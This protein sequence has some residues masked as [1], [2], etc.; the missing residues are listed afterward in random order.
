MFSVDF[1]TKRFT[2]NLKGIQF[3]AIPEAQKKSLFR[4]GFFNKKKM[5][6]YMSK[7]FRNPVKETLRSVLFKVENEDSMIF[8]IKKQKGKGNSPRKYLAP[9]EF[10]SGG[11]STAYETKFSYWFR[12]YS[13]LAVSNRYPVPVLDSPAVK[14]NKTGTGMSPSQYTQVKEGLIKSKGKGKIKGNQYRYFAIPSKSGRK[15]SKIRP[16]GIYRVKGN[17]LGLLF[18]L[19]RKQPQ[20]PQKFEFKNR[21][22]KHL[23]QKMPNIFT[24]ELRKAVAKFK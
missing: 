20:V 17:Q 15:A 1:D 3:S 16:M 23:N 5:S 4:F 2:Q 24:D 9:V 21:T 12:N 11:L 6:L 14:P 7:V 22:V 10:R 8:F 19:A 18:T 13:G